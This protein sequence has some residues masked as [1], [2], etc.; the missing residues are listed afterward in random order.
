MSLLGNGDVSRKKL[1]TRKVLSIQSHVVHG[2]VG[3]KAATF[4]L[5]YRE[6]DVDALNTV[7]FS[8]HPGCGKFT[9]FR[10]KATD[11]YQ[12]LDRGLLDGLQ[13]RYDAVLTGYLPCI[14]SLKVVGETVGE[15]CR[16]DPKLKW[17]LDPVLGDN[18]KL[19]VAEENVP[20]YREILETN[21]IYVVT[22]NQFEMETLTKV[23]IDSLSALKKSFE[24]FHDLYPKVQNIVVTSVELPHRYSAYVICAGYD[25]T[26]TASKIHYFRVPKLNAHFSGSGDLFSALLLD[27]LVPSE[28]EDE[29]ALSDALNMVLSL[30]DG[31]LQRTLELSLQNDEFLNSSRIINDLKLIQS[32]DLLKRS[33][34]KEDIKSLARFTEEELP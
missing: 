12:I 3:N 9:G 24:K 29:P 19:Y 25:T 30:V 33:D 8:N 2:Y 1:R 27:L 6:W 20:V 32:A 23:K 26:A 14:D 34:Q 15:M 21:S 17:V 10:S 11:I 13:M 28:A 4:P 5:Q 22:P 31:I 7:Q 16:K 18:G